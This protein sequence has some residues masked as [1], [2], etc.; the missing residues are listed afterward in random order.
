M[1]TRVS[2]RPLRYLLL[3]LVAAALVL[4]PVPALRDVAFSGS[5]P[6]APAV[7]TGVALVAPAALLAQL[8][9][10]GATTPQQAEPAGTVVPAG[11]LLQLG[12]AAPSGTVA[13]AIGA[14][15]ALDPGSAYTLGEVT[16]D[17]F[18]LQPAGQ[19]SDG[20]PIFSALDWGATYVSANASLNCLQAPQ[21]CQNA[22]VALSHLVVIGDLPPA[23]LAAS[24]QEAQERAT[25]LAVPTGS[26]AQ[27][28]AKGAALATRIAAEPDATPYSPYT[29]VSA[30]AGTIVQTGM[31]TYPAQFYLFENQWYEGAPGRDIWVYA[32]ELTQDPSQGVLGVQGDGSAVALRGIYL[33]PSEDG[34]V[35]IVSAVGEQLTLQAT[36][37]TTF[38]FDL[39]SHSFLGSSAASTS[40]STADP[41]ATVQ[42][43]ATSTPALP[44]DTPT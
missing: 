39:P 40:G 5:R 34:S 9:G 17:P 25:A 28:Q 31:S 42:P 13:L 19:L 24:L 8:A 15:L 3:A 10:E 18:M 32:G 4:A 21:P 35:H 16:Y 43:S 14:R 22:A 1:V 30:G 20:A 12:I 44:T 2:A 23:K 38:V 26:L 29:H 33:T 7:L 37:G 36:D 27:I 6:A 11:G 41:T